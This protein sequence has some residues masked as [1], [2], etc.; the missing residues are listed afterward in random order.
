MGIFRHPARPGL[1]DGH[2]LAFTFRTALRAAHP[3][4]QIG[5]TGSPP[6]DQ[7]QRLRLDI[8]GCTTSTDDA[9]EEQPEGVVEFPDVVQCSHGAKRRRPKEWLSMQYTGA[10]DTV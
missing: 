3:R 10:N 8:A 1:R 6:C 2:N 9:H 5:K 7:G 4:Y